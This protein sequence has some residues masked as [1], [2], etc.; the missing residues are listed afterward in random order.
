MPW[1]GL[2][3]RWML[4]VC[5]MQFLPWMHQQ[6]WMV[7]VAGLMPT[8]Q[9]FCERGAKVRPVGLESGSATIQKDFQRPSTKKDVLSL[10]W[11]NDN[12][13]KPRPTSSF[14]ERSGRDHS[15]SFWHW[16]ADSTFSRGISTSNRNVES[17]ARQITSSVVVEANRRPGP[18]SSSCHKT[19][20]PQ[21]VEEVK[22]GP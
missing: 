13:E 21:T 19:K 14:G 2:R 10:P 17:Q 4:C 15:V 7:A 16:L 11:A 22:Q 8:K 20:P 12:T 6:P 3:M 18:T 5:W 9:L 1:M